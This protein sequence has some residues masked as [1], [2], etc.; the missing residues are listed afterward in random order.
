MGEEIS[1]NKTEELA[2]KENKNSVSDQEN[3]P[4]EKA[5]E[6]GKAEDSSK[7]TAPDEPEERGEGKDDQNI[8]KTEDNDQYKNMKWYVVH[9]YSGRE[10]KVRDSIERIAKNSGLEDKF[11]NILVATEE[12]A[13]MKKGKKKVR[14]RKL[15]PSYIVIQME[16]SN[17]TWNLVENVTGVTHFVG[18]REKPL[19]IPK[20]DVDRILGRMEKREGIIPEVPFT[21]GEHVNVVDGPFS[22]FTGIVDEISPERG[23]L[24]VLVSI[25][26]RETP[27]ELDFL[28]VKPL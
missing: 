19:P 13:E 4:E 26:G 21:L 3:H 10:K 17:E 5:A 8:Q 2:D 23:K 24:K 27:V 9:T 1:K 6:A 22:E 28:Q 12:V 14:E 25:F 15:F 7:S 11:G 20:K 16:M 18:G